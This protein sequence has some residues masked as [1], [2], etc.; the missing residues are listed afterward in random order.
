MAITVGKSALPALSQAITAVLKAD[1][2]FT[3]LAAGPFDPPKEGQAFP[4]VDFGEHEERPWYTFQNTG[5]EVF[6]VM[7]IW[8]QQVGTSSSGF[9]QCYDILDAITGALETQT[10]VINDFEMTEKGFLLD[11][12]AKMPLQPDGVTK[13]LAI[14]FHTWLRRKTS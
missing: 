14:R 5:R 4:F 13:H 1:A 6:F 11:D 9:K 8:S 3:S 7:H 2:T 12:V 10:F